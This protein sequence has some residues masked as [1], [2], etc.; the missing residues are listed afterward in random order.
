MKLLKKQLLFSLFAL[1]AWTGA[2]AQDVGYVMRVTLTDGTVDSYLVADHPTVEFTQ[3]KVTVQSASVRAEYAAD[4]VKDYTFVDVNATN[5]EATTAETPEHGI[6]F[7]YVDGE[8]IS[9]RGIEA[10]T[11]VSVYS[12][13]GQKQNATIIRTPDGA[14]VS[15]GTLPTGTYII[16][17]R[18]IKSI[19]VLKR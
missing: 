11:P 18:N 8:N 10:T 14:N 15:L 12:I 17:I 19:K 3:D 5:I 1:G 4:D 6:T 9:I 13:G 7:K 16:N 2:T